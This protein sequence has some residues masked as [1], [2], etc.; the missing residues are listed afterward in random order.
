MGIKDDDV[1]PLRISDVIEEGDAAR[2]ASLRLIDDG[3]VADAKGDESR[4]QAR[5]ERALQVDASNPYAYLA[6]ARHHVETQ[7]PTRAL[8][9]LDR[10]H[11][12]LRMQGEIEPGMQVHLLGLRGGALYDAGQVEAGVELLDQAR[13]MSP[14]VWGDGALHP[15][16]LR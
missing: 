8:Q 12:L 13:E 1:E 7:D 6:I 11:S 10:A 16:E 9:F 5:Y 3:L 14:R 2:R 15:D 4:A